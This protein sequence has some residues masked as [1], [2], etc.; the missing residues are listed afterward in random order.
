MSY[1]EKLAE[2]V[3]DILQ[4]R[5]GLTQKRMFGGIAWLVD[6]NMSVV[7][8]SEGDLMVRVAPEDHDAMLAEPGAATMVMRGRPLRGWITVAPDACATPSA[9]TTWVERGL[10]YATT[11]PPK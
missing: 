1:D 9:L 3:R 5:P 4:D 10:A 2:R 6:G 8:R 7:V 11:L